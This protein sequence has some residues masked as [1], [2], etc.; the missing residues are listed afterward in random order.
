MFSG[1]KKTIKLL[2][3]RAKNRNKNVKI[4][5]G[6]TLGRDVCF[7]GKNV[8]GNNTKFSGKIGRGSYIG[9][10]CFINASIGRYCSIS[11]NV[12]VVS[13]KHPVS[14][15]VSTHPC[16][17]STK[18]QAGFT[19]VTKDLFDESSKKD[20]YSVI[21]GN[22][23]CIGYGV[24]ILSG[25]TIGDGAVIAAGAVVNHDV[26]PYSVVG[27]VPAKLIKKRFE[28]NQIEALLKL[29]WWDK[30]EEW[31][32]ENASEFGNVEGILSAAKNNGEK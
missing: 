20:G 12:S 23:V 16:F 5:S 29:K 21:I 6:V 22:D 17:Y 8:I 31:I 30:P 32:K 26:E 27:G 13:G 2:V 14:E 4:G 1:L 7:E 9:Q 15:F 19:Y 11:Y 10:N 3:I 18:K 24:I 25:V 28:D